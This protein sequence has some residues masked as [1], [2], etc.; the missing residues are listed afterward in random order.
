MMMMIDDDVDGEVD[1]WGEWRTRWDLVIVVMD[2]C[3]C[4]SD[5]SFQSDDDEYNC[6]EDREED[7]DDSDGGE[8]VLPVPHRRGQGHECWTGGSIRGL[9]VV[10]GS[11]GRSTGRTFWRVV[12]VPAGGM[13][14]MACSS[15]QSLPT[16][17]GASTRR[18]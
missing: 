6:G 11:S 15:M 7:A 12:D 16:H 1:G 9:R 5:V 8:L 18:L 17:G 14:A 2:K 3:A 4:D 13:S 10:V